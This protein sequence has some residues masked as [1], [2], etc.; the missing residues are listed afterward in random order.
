MDEISS[1]VAHDMALQVTE[2]AGGLSTLELNKRLLDTMRSSLYRLEPELQELLVISSASSDIA[3]KL[4]L[5]ISRNKELVDALASRGKV[6]P[7]FLGAL[8]LGVAQVATDIVKMALT[9][10]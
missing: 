9:R 2:A 4:S 6:A 1:K 5:K 3:K 7:R 8:A 10:Y